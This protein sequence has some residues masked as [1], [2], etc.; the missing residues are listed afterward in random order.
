MVWYGIN[1]SKLD[2][3]IIKPNQTKSETFKRIIQGHVVNIIQIILYLTG[4]ARAVRRLC[5]LTLAN[6][7]SKYS[8][9]FR[10]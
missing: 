7:S 2:F 6:P 10:F 1:V 4:K 9:Q 5:I 3:E 8:K